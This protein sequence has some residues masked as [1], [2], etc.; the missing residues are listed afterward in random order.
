MTQLRPHAAPEGG[1]PPGPRRARGGL[2]DPPGPLAFWV[3]AIV[4]LGVLVGNA[5]WGQEP[6]AGATDWPAVSLNWISASAAG[7]ALGLQAWPPIRDRL[8]LGEDRRKQAE[9]VEPDAQPMTR[10]EVRAMVTEGLQRVEREAE[11]QHRRI[12]ETLRELEARLLRTEERI[13][14]AEHASAERRAEMAR[15]MGEIASDVRHLRRAL[16]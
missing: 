2:A 16:E 13:T 9:P 10:A 14:T 15:E 4:V 8:G 11:G 12:R 5:A 6:G 7:L 3:L 1:R